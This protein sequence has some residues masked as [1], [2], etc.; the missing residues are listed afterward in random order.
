MIGEFETFSGR[1]TPPERLRDWRL[2]E[3]AGKDFGVWKVLMKGRKGEAF[4]TK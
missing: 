2:K 4:V 3:S 1:D